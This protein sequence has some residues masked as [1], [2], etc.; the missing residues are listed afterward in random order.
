MKKCEVLTLHRFMLHFSGLF[1]QEGSTNRYFWVGIVSFEL[2][3]I[4]TC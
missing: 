1:S 3:L 2:I 4:E